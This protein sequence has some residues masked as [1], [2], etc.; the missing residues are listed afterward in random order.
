MGRQAVEFTSGDAVVRGWLFTP[1]G[2]QGPTPAIVMVPGFSAS[3]RFTV[4]DFYAEAFAEIGVAALLVDARGFGLSD[5]DPRHEINAWDQAR[6]YRSA[7]EFLH[8]F[9]GI[10]PS[11]IAIWGVSLSAAVAAVVAAVDSR[12]A[13]V[14]LQAPAFGDDLSPANPDGS[15]FASIRETV[16]DADLD[17]FERTVDGPLPIVSPA[18]LSMPSILKT[19]TAF[20]WFINYGSR[21]GTGW[22]NQATIVRLVTPAPF[23][24][25][26]C[27]PLIVVPILMVVAEDDEMEG[28]DSDVARHVFDRANEPKELFEV[29]GG[30]FGAL[31]HDSP[32]SK[33]SASV[34]QRF[35]REHLI[36]HEQADHP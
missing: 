4:F 26:V 30:H 7:I 36:G 21:Y 34:Q 15:R 13:A 16:L 28:A 31:Y 19:L 6:D 11:R 5:G 1:D 9:D 23:D 35:L 12:V 33:L 10:D 22:E 20:H 25:Q 27:V 8:G 3:S 14:V 29:G 18:Q 17:S 2:S 32:E 24:A